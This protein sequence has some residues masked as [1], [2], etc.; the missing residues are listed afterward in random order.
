M[1]RS[2]PNHKLK[3]LLA[4]AGLSGEALARSINLAAA[5]NHRTLHYNRKSVAGWL[6]GSRPPAPVPALVAETLTRRI[7]RHVSIQ[8]TGLALVPD[9]PAD[10]LFTTGGSGRAALATLTAADTGAA[11]RGAFRALPFRLANKG[12]LFRTSGGT[13][14]GRPVRAGPDAGAVSPPPRPSAAAP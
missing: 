8:E 14:A 11:T 9:E 4:E 3:R 2:H 5:E 7:G 6:A 13:A 1:A 12:V 10:V